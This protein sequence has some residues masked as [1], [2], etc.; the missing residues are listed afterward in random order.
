MTYTMKTLLLNWGIHNL[1]KSQSWKSK[2]ERITSMIESKVL[3]L[4]I[5][6]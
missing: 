1:I 3:Q 5:E 2:Y 4:K 6:P